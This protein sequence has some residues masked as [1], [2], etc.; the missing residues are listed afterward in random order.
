MIQIKTEGIKEIQAQLGSFAG[1]QLPAGIMFG[2]ARMG[3]ELLKEN[4]RIMQSVFDAPTPFM[5]SS[6]KITHWPKKTELYLDIGLEETP[7]RD[8]SIQGNVLEPHIPGFGSGRNRKGMETW[9]RAGGFMGSSQWLMPARTFRFNQYG[10]VPGPTAQKM[11]ADVDAYSRAQY[12]SPIKKTKARKGKYIWGTMTSRSGKLFS[13]I[14]EVTGGNANWERGKWKLQMIAVDKAPRYEKRFAYFQLSQR[15]V[16]RNL[17]E[18][19]KTGLMR[20]LKTAR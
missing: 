3:G 2:L 1:S 4:R 12:N 10:N 17:P 20:A 16:D 8:V 15:Y 7:S 5:L 9:L 13:G 18:A 19:I 14:F 6:L 11:L